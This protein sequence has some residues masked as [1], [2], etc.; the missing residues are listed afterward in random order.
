[1]INAIMDKLALV[2]SLVYLVDFSDITNNTVKYRCCGYRAIEDSINIKS[3]YR[4][5]KYV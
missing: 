2:Y 4:R 1:M 3:G 5:I